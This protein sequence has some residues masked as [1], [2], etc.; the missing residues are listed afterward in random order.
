MYSS[1]L[2]GTR[3]PVYRCRKN[4]ATFIA[5]RY[6]FKPLFTKRTLEKRSCESSKR[7]EFHRCIFEER[8]KREYVV[9]STISNFLNN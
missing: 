7:I 2:E 6:S 5:T 4:K 8:K 3:L 1:T 9:A